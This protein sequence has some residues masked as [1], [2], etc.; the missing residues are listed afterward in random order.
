MNE[1]WNQWMAFWDRINQG[2]AYVSLTV[3]ALVYLM[4]TGLYRKDERRIRARVAIVFLVL[5]V[6]LCNPVTAF[7]YQK[8][9]G[10]TYEYETSFVCVPM[11]IL[12]AYAGSELVAEHVL[13]TKKKRMITM[14]AL[15]FVIMSTGAILPFWNREDIVKRSQMVYGRHDELIEDILEASEDIKERGDIPFLV[16]P[17][18][19]MSVIRYYD[20]GIRLAYGRDLWETDLMSHIHDQY[21]AEQIV[22]CQKMEDENVGATE[23]AELALALGCNMFVSREVL[24]ETFVEYHNLAL[25]A[26]N[27]ELYLYVR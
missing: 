21:S 16:A 13:W 14:V 22:L 2:G 17:K 1:A 4:Y 25:Y 20:G 26:E 11:L 19:I 6:I 7:V 9:I 3:L 23:V 18:G 12:I 15:L 24:T 8:I 27:D 5:M 10:R